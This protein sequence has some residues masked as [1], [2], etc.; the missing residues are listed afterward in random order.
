MAAVRSRLQ[1]TVFNSGEERLLIFANVSTSSENNRKKKKET[2]LCVSATIQQPV[3]IRIYFVRVKDDSFYKKESYNL[4]DV[5]M[6]DGIHPRRPSTLFHIYLGDKR[7]ILNA[8]SVEEKEAFVQELYLLAEKYLPIQKPEFVNI[9]L[10]HANAPI[11]SKLLAINAEDETERLADEDY[12][13]I[14]AKEES[15][16][17]QMLSEFNLNIS[18]A[19]AFHEQ[20]TKRLSDLDNTNIE[21]IMSSEQAVTKVIEELEACEE[22]MAFVSARLE[23]YDLLLKQVE[24]SVEI[25]EEKSNVE[26]TER[27]N[28]S[29]LLKELETLTRLIM[30]VSREQLDLLQRPKLNNPAGTN[31]TAEA[32]ACAVEFLNANTPHVQLA[33]YKERLHIVRQAL[34]TFV[35]V[36]YAS[37]SATMDH[38][39]KDYMKSRDASF[40]G[41][42]LDKTPPSIPKHSEIYHQLNKFAKINGL[43]KQYK[44]AVYA[45]I[46]E[47]YQR[48]SGSIFATDIPQFYELMRQRMDSFP[49]NSLDDLKPFADLLDWILSELEIV[50]EAEQ[51]FLKKILHVPVVDEDSEP[52]QL[53]DQMRLSMKSIFEPLMPDC[54]LNFARSSSQ[55]GHLVVAKLFV[56]LVSHLPKYSTNSTSYFSMIFGNFVVGMKRVFDEQMNLRMD[57]YLTHKTSKKHRVGVLPIVDDFK[58]LMADYD[59]IFDQSERRSDLDKWAVKLCGAV[60][61]AI[62]AA[63]GAGNVKMPSTLI[64]FENF[65]KLH[66]TLLGLK[67]IDG[68]EK[69]RESVKKKYQENMRFYVFDYL[70]R[71]L[72]KL[73]LF[74]ESVE[75]AIHTGIRAEEISFQQQF[76]RIELKKAIGAYPGKDVKKGLESLYAKVEK[77]LGSDS[78]LLQVVWRDMQEEFL[79]QLKQYQTLIARC[80]PNS[81][82]NLEFSIEDVLGYFSEIAQQH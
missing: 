71:P 78:Q 25:I 1:Q 79:K 73:H 49:A 56:H 76:S 35:D 74:F 22:Q 29:I 58:R 40:N 81:R 10:P 15:D 65:H 75:Y 16:F 11:S 42:S 47:V 32:V 13:P 59:K 24:E 21:T 53:H 8:S 64:R 63:A 5:R 68:L 62:D 26:I 23:G 4:R 51:K 33:A 82:I 14:S 36:Y 57:S 9:S 38:L 72:E 50:V 17:L 45:R 37:I 55:K 61:E 2:Y 12:Q 41:S 3:V 39:V 52:Q 80:Y 30:K 60:I 44:P 66:L 27:Q 67:R 70:G 7:H 54:F 20:L 6:V 28:M 18:Q 48:H 43:I 46:L 31:L 34:S 77:H 69:L 19:T